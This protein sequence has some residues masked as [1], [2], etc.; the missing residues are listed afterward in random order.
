MTNYPAL[1]PRT[2]SVDVDLPGFGTFRKVPVT[3]FED[4]AGRLRSPEP[5]KTGLWAYSVEDPPRGWPTADWP[6]DTPDPAQ[7]GEYR[8]A[9]EPI[10]QLPATR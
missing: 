4:S 5:S 1:S 3:A 7:L 8:S 2:R 6:T 9:V 10:V